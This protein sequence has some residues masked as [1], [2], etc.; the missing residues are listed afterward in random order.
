M[1]HRTS[2]ASAGVYHVPVT[3]GVFVWVTMYG[4]VRH[5]FL[6]TGT[7]GTLDC[8]L[9]WLAYGPI[10]LYRHFHM[11]GLLPN[12]LDILVPSS[13]QIHQDRTP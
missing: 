4:H 2:D 3:V 7:A 5:N 6:H 12:L 11:D 13:C 8:A 9:L 1:P 10:V